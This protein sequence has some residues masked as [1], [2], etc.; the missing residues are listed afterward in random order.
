VSCHRLVKGSQSDEQKSAFDFCPSEC[1]GRV[2]G[3]VVSPRRRITERFRRGRGGQLRRSDMFIV[4]LSNEY[5]LEPQ[6]GGTVRYGAGCAAPTE[7][8][9]ALGI[10]V[11]INMSLLRSWPAADLCSRRRLGRFIKSAQPMPEERLP[12]NRAPLARRGCAYRWPVQTPWP[13]S[14]PA[15]PSRLPWRLPATGAMCLG[16]RSRWPSVR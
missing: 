7:L 13:R 8:K 2:S 15:L 6:R 4:P 3:A 10:A 12:F 16:A 5:R 11:T 14:S 9:K 1:A